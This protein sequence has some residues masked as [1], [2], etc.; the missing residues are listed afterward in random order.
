VWRAQGRTHP[1]G[2]GFRG[3]LDLVPPRV[4]E[5]QLDAAAR[6][7]TPEILLSILYA[8][9]P[10]EISAEVAPLV[11]AGCRHFILANVGTSFTGEGLADLWRLRD[12]MRRLKRL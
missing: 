2:A 12:L 7:M 5:A 8:G 3:F 11:D 10:A 4:T 9:S 1:L 6:T